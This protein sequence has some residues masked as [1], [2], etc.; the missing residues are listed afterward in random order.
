MNEAQH[1]FQ[2]QDHLIY[3]LVLH[4]AECR[5]S[6]VLLG[7]RAG[8]FLRRGNSRVTGMAKNT[9]QIGPYSGEKALTRLDLRTREGRYLRAIQDELTAQV[10][11]DPTAAEKLLIRLASLKALRVAL[12]APKIM[13]S[14]AIDERADRQFLAWA[15]SLRRDLD[16]LG[17]AKRAQSSPRL[18]DLLG[19][20]TV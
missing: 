19:G 14:E 5:G 2:G 4:F 3:N 9:R 10:G 20:K 11:D 6:A 16:T 12:M 18:A 15:N 17:I 8:Q 1:H 13:T 7:F